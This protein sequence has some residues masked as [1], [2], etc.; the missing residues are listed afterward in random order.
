MTM[1]NTGDSKNVSHLLEKLSEIHW[2]LASSVERAETEAS[3]K[4]EALLS[5]HYSHL[6]RGR[7]ME[8]GLSAK[9]RVSQG[10]EVEIETRKKFW[11]DSESVTGD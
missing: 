1:S 7:V 11:S 10:T 4:I 9:V 5:R 6:V 8:K 3:E 2:E